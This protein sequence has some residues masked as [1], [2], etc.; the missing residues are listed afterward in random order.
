MKARQP[1]ECGYAVNAG[2]RL[3]YEVHGS[4][5]TTI[6]L[7]PTWSIIDA[8]V[9]KMQVAYLAR[10]FRVLTYDPRGNGKSD[11]PNQPEAYGP[12]PFTSD[13]VA[14]LD[15]TG[16][17]KAVFVGYCFGVQPTLLVARAHPER[18][19]GIIALNTEVPNFVDFPERANADFETPR[20]S[21]EGWEKSN[22]N[23]W[24][25]DWSGYLDQFFSNVASEPHSTK[26]YDDLMG[27]GRQTDASTMLCTI[28]APELF[29]DVAEVED[30]LRKLTCPVL[31]IAGDQDRIV[32]TE[33]THRLAELTDAELLIIEGG[34]HAV[35]A[36]YPVVVNRAIK[37]FVDRIAQP[38]PPRIQW[39][40]ALSRPRKAL[41]VSSPIGLGHALRDIAV[42]QALRE[43]VPDLQIEWLAQ[44]PVTDVLRT[45]GEIIHPASADLSSEAA[46]WEGEAS[47][48]DLHAFYAFRRMDEI[49]LA[50]YMVFDDVTTDTA[51]DLWVGDESWEVDHFLHENPERK[52]A[53]YVFAT[54]VV[55]F[56]PVDPE[57]DPREI[58]LCADYNAEMIEHRARN[59][60]VRDASLFIGGYDEL[61]SASFGPGLPDVRSWTKQWFDSVPYIVPFNPLDYQDPAELRRRLRYDEDSPLLVSA[62]GGTAVGVDLLCLVAEGFRYLRKEIPSARMLMVTGPRIDP[63]DIPDAEGMTKRGYVPN[64]FEHLA[65]CDTAIVQGGLST[66]MELVAARR[67]FIYFPLQSHW[68]QRHFVRHR[69]DYYRAG[70]PM[71]YA[72]TTPVDLADTMLRS[73][74][75]KPRYRAVPNDGAAKAAARIQPLLS[76]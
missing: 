48:H 55:G 54:D 20:D 47:E 36:R 30:I 23:Y 59:P 4:G 19:Q 32:P 50:N 75:R 33:R 16:T 46:H 14:V 61:P 71:E 37:D 29:S 42:A 52:T 24:Q 70:I 38:A 44:P 1:D 41:W 5:P 26:L 10:H 67:P 34:G 17:A 6:L 21:Y 57:G 45:A 3:Y 31:A 18:V 60:Q 72:D 43:R 9:W 27:W 49:L 13:V 22:R 64:L 40:T 15:A 73:L 7:L 2:V 11:R 56:L 8:Q 53:P 58:D 63:R 69:L 35:H 25:S 65:A 39:R 74:S 62:V 28:D 66:T 51:Y 12:E 76:R 68:E